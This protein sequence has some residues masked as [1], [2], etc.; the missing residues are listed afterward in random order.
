MYKF[1]DQV[2]TVLALIIIF[3]LTI[4]YLSEPVK[5]DT[6][7]QF[8]GISA[9][10]ISKD[11]NT[12]F[13]NAFIIN[14]NEYSIGYLKNSYGEDSFMA[15]YR[16]YKHT[17]KDLVTEVTIGAVKGYDKC[18]G[19]FKDNTKKDKVFACPLVVINVTLK[20]NTVIEPVIS[21]WGDA[22][23]LTGRYKF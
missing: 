10:L 4:G 12:W 21:L 1:I 9:H 15:T 5:A 17:A 6:S 7:I 3:I 19:A 13:H 14:H 23:V 22:V 20:T 16:V 8:G 18:Y 2:V 11:T